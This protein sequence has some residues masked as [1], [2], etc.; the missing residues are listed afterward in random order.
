MV[1]FQTSNST[2]YIDQINK[3][4][5]G[6][7]FKNNMYHY[8]EIQAIVGRNGMIVLADGKIIRT[9]VIKRYI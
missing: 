7:I 4:I 8:R 1:G 6:G 5:T 2:Y 9:G 3:T